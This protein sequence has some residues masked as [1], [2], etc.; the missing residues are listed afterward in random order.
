MPKDGV[1]LF[2][3]KLFL[4]KCLWLTLS[5]NRQL[6]FFSLSLLMYSMLTPKALP[7]DSILRTSFATSA[8]KVYNVK[9]I[10]RCLRT[11]FST[12]HL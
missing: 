10:F 12:N 7:I 3:K 5:R 11:I 9:S 1:V 8:G 2:I 4:K 6:L